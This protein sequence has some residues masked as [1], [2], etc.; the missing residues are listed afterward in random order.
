MSLRSSSTIGAPVARS[1]STV[2]PPVATATGMRA[3]GNRTRDIVRRVA[4]DDDV[5]VVE[6]AET[7]RPRPIDG[8][9]HQRVAIRRIVAERAAAEVVPQIEVA[10]LDARS[11]LEV[12][13]EQAEDHVVSRLQR[14]QQFADAR[15]HVLDAVAT[16]AQ[17]LQR[18]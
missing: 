12:A 15:H 7:A 11:L 18:R 17:S 2:K 14:R 4:D 10:E 9:R 16:G 6:R 1:C 8:E 13:G 3:Y 5:R